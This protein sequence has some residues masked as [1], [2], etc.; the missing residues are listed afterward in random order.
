[1]TG[2]RRKL[3]ASRHRR[4]HDDDDMDQDKDEPMGSSKAVAPAGVDQ[5]PHKSTYEAPNIPAIGNLSNNH[6]PTVPPPPVSGNPP[7]WMNYSIFGNDIVDPHKPH[8]TTSSQANTD[9]S[10][11]TNSFPTWADH[12][13]INTPQI[14]PPLSTVP[15]L[16]APGLPNAGNNPAYQAIPYHWQLGL[17]SP[18]PTQYYPPQTEHL[19]GHRSS[20]AF[21]DERFGPRSFPAT[22]PAAWGDQPSAGSFAQDERALIA[23][24]GFGKGF[25][26]APSMP[27]PINSLDANYFYPELSAPC[28]WGNPMY[29]IGP[30]HKS[31]LVEKYENVQYLKQL[32]EGMW[33]LS[34][35]QT[36]PYTGMEKKISGDKPGRCPFKRPGVET[37][38]SGGKPGPFPFKQPVHVT[39]SGSSSPQSDWQNEDIE[40]Q[41]TYHAESSAVPEDIPPLQEFVERVT[42]ATCAGCQKPIS[43]QPH[44]V[45]E[46]TRSWAS[47]RGGKC[48]S[49]PRSRDIMQCDTHAEAHLPRPTI[50]R[51]PLITSRT[52]AT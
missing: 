36:V 34:Y 4:H 50:P 6:G 9:S 25:T 18:N 45:I 49:L 28:P 46:M 23:N 7:N 35:D 48:M 13:N 37:D 14:G 43:L 11:T 10:S 27:T 15:S 44:D 42:T 8:D 19:S 1:M 47:V 40:D 26:P 21:L 41:E 5:L 22:S 16:L 33:P 39:T 2:R 38:I 52:I 20:A 24:P 3:R 12:S 32:S 31:T 51:P 29:T 17:P 30:Q